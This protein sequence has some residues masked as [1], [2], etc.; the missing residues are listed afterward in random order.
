MEAQ[1]LVDVRREDRALQRAGH[2]RRRH[3]KSLIERRHDAQIRADLLSQS[4][5]AQTI[6]AAL[7]AALRAHDVAADGRQSAAGILDQRA[8]GHVRTHVAWLDGLHELAI[9]VV[10]HAHQPRLDRLHEGDQLTNLLDRERRP[11]LIALGAL[12]GDQLGALVDGRADAVPVEAAVG[13]QIHLTVADAVLLQRAGGRS[14]ADDLL[15]RIVGPAHRR[16]Q[17]VAGQQV[18]RQRHRQR[19]GAAG[20][21]RAHQRGLG[22][23]GIGVDALQIVA[24]HVVIAIAGG[25]G[26]ALGADAVFLHRADDLGLIIL[27]HAVDLIEPLP[28]CRQNVLSKLKDLRTYAEVLIHRFGLHG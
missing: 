13:Q 7:H 15:Q 23:E 28:E 1:L 4:G 2:H 10:H 5:R 9:A 21:L 11:R 17:L 24:T 25:G 6:C 20:D 19:M 26:K 18:G 12:D 22:V 8:D 16:Q 14:D 27:R 3:E